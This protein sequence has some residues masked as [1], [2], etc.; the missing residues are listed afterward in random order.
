[1]FRRRG[2]GRKH[3]RRGDRDG[4]V[5]I[6][7]IGSWRCGGGGGQRCLSAFSGWVGHKQRRASGDPGDRELTL[8]V[9]EVFAL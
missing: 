2:G 5:V 6:R 1:M 7:A 8:G 9:A 3:R 4:Q